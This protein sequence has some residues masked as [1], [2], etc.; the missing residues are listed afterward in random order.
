[1]GEAEGGV[2][3]T[4]AGLRQQVRASNRPELTR[5]IPNDLT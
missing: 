1:M 4:E 2:E 3:L 5:Y